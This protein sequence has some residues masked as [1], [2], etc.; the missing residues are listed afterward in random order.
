[1]KKFGC[2]EAV[3]GILFRIL[4]APFFDF[5]LFDVLSF[6]AIVAPTFPGAVFLFVLGDSFFLAFGFDAFVSL[7]SL[8]RSLEHF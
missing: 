3:K 6:D 2:K 8:L 4:F 7:R 5:A 1:M